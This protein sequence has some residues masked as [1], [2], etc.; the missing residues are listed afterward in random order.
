MQVPRCLVLGRLA[1]PIALISLSGGRP[2]ISGTAAQPQSAVQGPIPGPRGHPGTCLL[3]FTL[4]AVRQCLCVLRR[5]TFVRNCLKI[6]LDL[7]SLE[8][9]SESVSRNSVTTLSFLPLSRKES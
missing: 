1:S 8:R 2:F 9:S 6:H 5:D 7:Y 4:C 3:P